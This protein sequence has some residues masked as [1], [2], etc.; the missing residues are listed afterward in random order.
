MVVNCL[1]VLPTHQGKRMRYLQKFKLLHI[2][3][4]PQSL[5]KADLLQH[6]FDLVTTVHTPAAS[7]GMSTAYVILHYIYHLN[8]SPG[9]PAA[10]FRY[11]Q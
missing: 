2:P 3:G 6:H 11:Q 7:T 4:Y 5:L 10:G 1:P 8:V 9:R